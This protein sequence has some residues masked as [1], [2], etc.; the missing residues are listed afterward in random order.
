MKRLIL[1]LLMPGAF[2]ACQTKDQTI[3]PSTAHSSARMEVTPGTNS[4][5]LIE[6][7]IWPPKSPNY[8]VVCFYAK[9]APGSLDVSFPLK[10]YQNGVYLG[11]IKEQ[12][13]GSAQGPLYDPTPIKPDQRIMATLPTPLGPV[14]YQV[15]II[16]NTGKNI[17]S[18]NTVLAYP[19]AISNFNVYPNANG[20][21]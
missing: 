9:R 1:A 15:S 20:W 8:S 6:Y 3:V 19:S 12:Y 7:F 4:T 16:D 14:N 5:I 18:I 17:G 13:P 11:Q 10:V 2:T 21:E